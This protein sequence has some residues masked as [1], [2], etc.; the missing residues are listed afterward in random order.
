MRAPKS[1][2]VASG[3][4]K[5]KPVESGD[6]ETSS[7]SSGLTGKKVTLSQLAEQLENLLE[8]PVQ[9]LTGIDGVY[10]YRLAFSP[11]GDDQS[12]PSLLTAVREQLGLRIEPR[13]VTVA[14]LVV[15]HIDRVPNGELICT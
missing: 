14:L 7:G 8:R 11:K 3:G 4:L 1:A 5:P 13:K 12:S 9:D 6:S 2:V 10:D 15:D